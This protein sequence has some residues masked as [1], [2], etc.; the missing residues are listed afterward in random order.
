ELQTARLRLRGHRPADFPALCALWGDA[1]V[2]RHLGGPAS[3]EAVW[4]RMLRYSGH[5]AQL[6]FGYW[7]IECRESGGYLGEAGLACHRRLLSPAMPA[8][9]PEAGWVLT[10]AAEG[11]GLAAEAMAAVLAWGDRWLAQDQRFA[12]ID[13]D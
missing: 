12:L 3:P 1:T 13:A 9:R 7:L 2:T 10:G 5:W 8:D 11:R 6:G 4:A